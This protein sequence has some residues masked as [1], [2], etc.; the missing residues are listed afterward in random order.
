MN[1]N[2]QDT[3]SDKEILQSIFQ[4]LAK[5]G[6]GFVSLLQGMGVTI[7]YFVR[8]DKIITQQYPENRASLTMMD[9]FRGHL[10]MNK[11]A[12]DQHQCTGCGICE[13]ACPNGTISVLT[14]KDISGRKIL[15]KYIYR[16]SQCTLC[17]LCIESCPFGALSM[18]KDFELATYDRKLLTLTLNKS[19][20]LIQPDAPNQH[21][22]DSL[23][24]NISEEANTK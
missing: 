13:K 15:G 22:T 1:D 8:P 7:S 3:L 12:S 2:Q 10:I 23:R 4:Y 21:L 14:T 5:I 18:G 9:R 20:K 16:L 17:N 24:H 11:D 6:S 19:T